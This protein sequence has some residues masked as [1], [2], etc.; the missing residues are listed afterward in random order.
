M[1]GMRSIAP[2]GL[3]MPD[4]LKEKIQERAK[5][6]GRSM[7]S[8]IIQILEDAVGGDGNENSKL[9]A[10]GILAYMKVNKGKDGNTILTMDL[11]KIKDMSDEQQKKDEN[12]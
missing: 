2:F 7:N 4:E 12:K 10:A 3:R 1:K 11:D 5:A 6:N 8:E 9:V